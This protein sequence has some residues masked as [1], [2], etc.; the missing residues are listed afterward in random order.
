MKTIL[1]EIFLQLGEKHRSAFPILDYIQ[2]KRDYSVGVVLIDEQHVA[3]T[4]RNRMLPELQLELSFKLK[5][6]LETVDAVECFQAE[7]QLKERYDGERLP[8]YKTQTMIQTIQLA[9]TA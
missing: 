8:D 2:A 4:F 3:P 5:A 9:T 6:N 1:T 7:R